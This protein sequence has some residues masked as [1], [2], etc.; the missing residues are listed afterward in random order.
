MLEEIREAAPSK[1]LCYDTFIDFQI[2][3]G[4]EPDGDILWSN[5][6][7]YQLGGAN[8]NE[9]LR[10]QSGT[11]NRMIA[12]DVSAIR[13]IPNKSTDPTLITVELDVK[14]PT[15][16]GHYYIETITGEAKIRN[17]G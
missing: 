5:T 7:R 12:N 9:L 1:I 11:G 15:V 10:T 8:N 14:R 17:G 4:L 6:I 2:P 13:F 3:S 16:K